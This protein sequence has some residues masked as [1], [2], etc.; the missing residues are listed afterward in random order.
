MTTAER[1]H[2]APAVAASAPPDY[3]VVGHMVRD[4]V[5][6]GFVP[7]GTATYAGLTALTLGRRVGVVTSVGP[8]F[9]PT[10]I[11]PGAELVVRPAPTT[12]TFEN[13]YRNGRRQQWLR[14]VAARLDLALITDTW[15]QAPIIHLAPL[16][17]EIGIEVVLGLHGSRLLGLTPQGWLRQWD[18]RG[19]VSRR[20]WTDAAAA[21]ATADAVVLS[22]E[23]VDGDWALLD[24]FA[25]QARLLVVTQ[26]ARGCT[27]HERGRRW[28]VPA[29]PVV[30]VDATG[31]GDV[32]AAAFFLD[33][34]D[35]GNP[36]GAA[37]FA[38]CVASF[39][40]EALGTGGIPDQA[41]IERRLRTAEPVV[42]LGG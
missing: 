19:L 9:A 21:L 16:A 30:E 42:V 17:D 5:E 33:L 22:E 32:F 2:P 7:G 31:A 15:R 3:V 34:I 23:D 18:A 11:L 24:Q 8:E 35:H 4:V 13:V 26:G 25:R 6:R 40:V 28:H 20:S 39:A 10:Q 41:A 36:I 12:T 37:R 1:P 29:F 38:N 14:S 27:V